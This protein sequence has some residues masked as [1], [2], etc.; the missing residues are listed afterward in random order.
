MLWLVAWLLGWLVGDL[1]AFVL[2]LALHCSCLFEFKLQ[3]CRILTNVCCD[4]L[5]VAGL[6]PED[7]YLQTKQSYRIPAFSSAQSQLGNTCL[8]AAWWA[9]QEESLPS[10][11]ASAA[12]F[13]ILDLC[14][15]PRKS[16]DF[17]G[18]QQ[19]FCGR[20]LN[21][22][23]LPKK[24]LSFATCPGTPFNLVSTLVNVCVCVFTLSNYLAP[25]LS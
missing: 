11:I 4:F 12:L 15:Y 19:Q 25:Q 5:K 10:R 2:L 23:M 8:G 22:N 17:L 13:A 9:C 14:W 16:K 7:S 21:E 1:V 20:C 24:L 18:Q 6:F 3:I